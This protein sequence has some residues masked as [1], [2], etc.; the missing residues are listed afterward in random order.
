MCSTGASGYYGP[1]AT[2]EARPTKRVLIVDDLW[3]VRS[4]LGDFFNNFEHAHAYEVTAAPHADAALDA[5]T[6]ERFDLI[7]LDTHMPPVAKPPGTDDN[8]AGHQGI[9]LLRQIR[10]IGVS[11][12]VIMMSGNPSTGD[13]AGALIDDA[14]GYLFKPF[15]FHELERAV[16]LPSDPGRARPA[17]EAPGAS[18]VLRG[19]V[20]HAAIETV[21]EFN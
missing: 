21:C 14:V 4:V 13:V 10:A 7:L 16:A 15:G 17:V 12:P 9:D 3:M 8:W 2:G 19:L 18:C 1:V 6:R 11:A 20:A 5:L